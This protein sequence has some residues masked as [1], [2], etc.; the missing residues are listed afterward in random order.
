MYIATY[1]SLCKICVRLNVVKKNKKT[2]EINVESYIRLLTKKYLKTAIIF[3]KLFI[4]ERY[5][6]KDFK[7]SGLGY[8]KKMIIS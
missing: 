4:K 2:V 6:Q 3:I 1:I 8:Y 7:Y 5:K